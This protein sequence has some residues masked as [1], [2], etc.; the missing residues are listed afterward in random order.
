M[1]SLNGVSVCVHFLY[2]S[3][4]CSTYVLHACKSFRHTISSD[5]FYCCCFGWILRFYGL[6][7]TCVFGCNFVWGQNSFRAWKIQITDDE[8]GCV[9]VVQYAASCTWEPPNIVCCR[10]RHRSYI[11]NIVNTI[12]RTCII[13][14][15]YIRT[16]E[17][18][19]IQRQTN[20]Q[21]KAKKEKKNSKNENK[22][23]FVYKRQCLDGVFP[24]SSLF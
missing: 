10:R 19:Y 16:R 2:I 23:K 4:R 20:N 15:Y 1:C 5:I 3:V 14:L 12:H 7:A 13:S 11:M 9:W 8:D 17:N 24:C 18:S 22:T 21:N 6:L